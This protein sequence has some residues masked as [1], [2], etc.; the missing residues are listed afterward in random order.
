ML[1][2]TFLSHNSKVL[3]RIDTKVGSTWNKNVVVSII[4]II[5]KRNT[6]KARDKYNESK[7]TELLPNQDKYKYEY[8]TNLQNSTR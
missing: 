4:F 5:Y 6:S 1:Y 8:T 7:Q 3:I 2:I